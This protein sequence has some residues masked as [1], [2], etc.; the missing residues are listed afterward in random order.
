MKR[1]VIQTGTNWRGDS[2]WYVYDNAL[3]LTVASYEDLSGAQ[4]FIANPG[5]R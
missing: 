1:Y 5:F 4:E 3:H 2:V